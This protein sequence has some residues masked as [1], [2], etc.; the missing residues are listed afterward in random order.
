MFVHPI[1]K[2]FVIHP[3]AAWVHSLWSPSASLLI[4]LYRARLNSQKSPLSQSP[5]RTSGVC[6]LIWELFKLFPL[7]DG[8]TRS[9]F[10]FTSRETY[11]IAETAF[12]Q[13]EG[14]WGSFCSS[15]TLRHLFHWSRG[16]S[17]GGAVIY[18]NIWWNSWW[19]QQKWCLKHLYVSTSWNKSCYYLKHQWA[20]QHI[21]MTQW[22]QRAQIPKICTP[23]TSWSCPL[24]P[25]QSLWI[26][27]WCWRRQSSAT[28]FRYWGL[29]LS[30]LLL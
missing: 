24:V 2:I 26:L 10:L 9:T 21:A 23:W 17:F 5:T 22:G 14:P 20:R 8:W 7:I 16:E 30:G 28:L 25:S 6:D 19:R 4:T 29:P 18:G 1:P 27:F 13:Q 11:N 15:S 12:S 3:K